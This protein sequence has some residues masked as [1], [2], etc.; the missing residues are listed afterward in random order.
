MGS[1]GGVAELATNG[2]IVLAIGVAA[3]AGLVSFLCDPRDDPDATGFC[4]DPTCG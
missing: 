3:L 2:P 4:F 1:A